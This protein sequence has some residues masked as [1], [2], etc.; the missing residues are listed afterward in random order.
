MEDSQEKDYS[1]LWNDTFPNLY[2]ALV[3][4][5]RVNVWRD[6]FTSDFLKV[7]C[8]EIWTIFLFLKVLFRN[9]SHTNKKQNQLSKFVF[10]QA[11]VLKI[12]KSDDFREL[13]ENE[14]EMAAPRL[15]TNIQYL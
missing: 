9:I 13:Y 15:E 10:P 3:Y 6:K 7:K 2:D 1:F 12:R 4:E 14:P 8:N 5:R 11:V